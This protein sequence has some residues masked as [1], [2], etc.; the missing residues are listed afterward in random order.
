MRNDTAATPSTIYRKDYT[1]PSYW[2][3][4]VDMGFDLDP[5]S[6]RVATRIVMRRNPA[7]L[8]KGIVL[9]GEEL[10]LISLRLNG[11]QLKSG[12]YQLQGGTLRIPL[13]P[14]KVTLE[15]ETLTQPEK[16]TSLMGLYVSNGNF[17]TQC[18]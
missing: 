12:Q 5:A 2:V 9:V 6:T 10:E 1:A 8:D 14:A 7:S 3:D 15:I 13:A 11:K 17:F 16:N 4:T 18:E